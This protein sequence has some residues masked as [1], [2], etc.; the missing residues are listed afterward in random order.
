MLTISSLSKR[1]GDD[2]VLDRVSCTVQAGERVGLVGPNGCG[3]STLLKII[4]GIE[5]ADSG[6]VSFVPSD[7]SIGYLPQGWDVPADLRV[8]EALLDAQ[9]PLTD[10]QARLA[11]LETEMA[12]AG[13]SAERLDQLLSEYGQLQER[14]EALGG[15]DLEH[16]IAQVRAGLGLDQLPDDQL[17]QQL[18][19]GQKTRLALARLLLQRP[20]LLLLDEPTNHLDVEA[21]AWLE[22]FLSEY[23]G[24]ALIVSHDRAFLDQTV[25]RI[26]E[27][28]PVEAERPSK[29]VRSS[30]GS[31]TP[32]K[33][34]QIRSYVGNYSD[35]MEAK[36]HERELLEERYKRQQE[37]IG[38]VEGDI[39]RLK[40][41]ALSVELTTTPAQ[42]TIR[43]Y[44]KKVAKKAKSRER[45]LE[46]FLESDEIVSKPQQGWGIKLDFRQDVEGARVVLRVEDLHFSYPTSE[47]ELLSGISFEL[48]YGERVALVGPNGMGKTTLLKLITNHLQPTSGLCR[49]GANVQVGYLSQEQELLDPRKT[50]IET[51]RALVPWNETECRNFLHRYLFAADE[52]FRSVAACSFGERARLS[53]ALLVAQGCSFLILDEPI[54][55][56]DIPARERFE[57]ALEDFGGTI[58]AVAHDRYFLEQFASRVLALRDG[59]LIDYHGSYADFEEA[60]A[61]AQ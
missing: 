11:E 5:Q 13:L 53:L 22:E 28:S 60:L 34:Q 50:V 4:A 33:P 40:G 43:R 46:R 31:Y 61:E 29:Q 38:K 12:Q 52:V 48:F 37:Y 59:K 23:E 54:N 49:L 51:L 36:Q 10:V 18:S 55:H 7:L 45:K 19:G 6:S 32:P 39:A 56:L 26:L 47:R 44:A 8:A 1:F 2:L 25:T 21:V 35:F 30:V 42:P 20:T 58:L 17:V 3:K 14:F 57:Q 41:Q 27:M 24:A 9:G 15:Y 16:Q